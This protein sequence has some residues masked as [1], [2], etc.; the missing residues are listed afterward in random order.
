MRV[1]HMKRGLLIRN[2]QG[3]LP[4]N[5]QIPSGPLFRRAAAVRLAVAALLLVLGCSGADS[6]LYPE[7]PHDTPYYY[8]E[9]AFTEMDQS[10][11]ACLRYARA[12]TGVEFVTA[13]VRSTPNTMLIGD[14]AAGL[15]D[16]WEIGSKTD[17]RGVLILFVEADQTLKI[18]VSYELEPFLTDA[19]CSSF[20]PTIKSYYA[21]RYFGDVFDMIVESLSRRILL[22]ITEEDPD[23]LAYPAAHPDILEASDTFLSG[24]GGVIEDDYYYEKN[25]KLA[26]IK[27]LPVERIREFDTDR[28]M[29][30]VVERYLRSLRE[31][32]NY[33][34]LEL[35][36][37]GGQMKRLEYPES[38]HFYRSR[39]EDCRRGFP[40]EIKVEGDLAVVRFSEDTS[41]P[42]FMRR[43]PNG[44]WKVD[45]ARAWVSSW[46]DFAGNK[47]GPMYR[48]HPWMFAFPEYKEKKSLCRVPEPFPLSR[49]LKDEIRRLD[50][51]MLQ[52]PEE[53]SNYFDLAD[54][55]C[56]ECMWLATAIDLV[57]RGLELD[58]GNMPYRWLAIDMHYRFPSPEP[59]AG[60]FEA[61]LAMNPRD[62]DAL[63]GYSYHCWQFTMEYRKAI[64][65]L[66]RGREAEVRITGKETHYRWY[67]KHYRETYWSEVAVYWSAPRKVWN[68]IWIFWLS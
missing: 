22:E 36:T 50:E 31:G 35:L 52:N 34:F 38:P 53:A 65:F 20:Q 64:K 17:G 15:F 18:E 41:F 29:V 46:Q 42:I 51:A 54:I 47:S 57:E 23:W 62:A 9:T 30:T 66:R 60:H 13:I 1:M 43:T 39:W 16:E 48:D 11:R 44:F 27:P 4:T 63:Y 3:G 26:F 2:G 68:F 25:A 56:W 61:L 49:S 24:G 59:N 21:G 5:R 28:N 19:Y 14:Y 67:L 7:R 33:P 37:E 40:Y 12:R 10:S 58:P 55:F 6:G 32:I 8:N 45:A